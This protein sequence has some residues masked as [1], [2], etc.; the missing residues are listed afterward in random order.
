MFINSQNILA[1]NIFINVR[2]ITIVLSD[3]ITRENVASNMVGKFNSII[4]RKV[5]PVKNSN[6]QAGFLT[7]H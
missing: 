2:F 5:R 1:Y 3:D 7:F 6:L 4:P